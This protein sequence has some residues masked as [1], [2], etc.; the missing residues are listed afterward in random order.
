[1]IGFLD[2]AKYFVEDV[3]MAEIPQTRASL[4]VRL[5]DQQDAEAWRQFVQV[6]A[7]LVYQLCRRKGLQDADA[8][9]LTQEVLRHV[10]TSVGRLEYDPQ[11][12]LF[13]SW[14]FTLAHRK[15]VDYFR[16]R[17]RQEQGSG[18]SGIQA[19]LEEQPAL[20][21]VKQWDLDYQ[22]QVFAWAAEQVRDRFS[23]TTWQ[24]F[25]LTAVE[26]RDSHQTADQ[27]GMTV[28]AVYLAKSR[29]MARLKEQIKHLDAEE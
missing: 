5:R 2:P 19:I 11:R 10:S 21:E 25:W 29:V 27:L 28:A 26:N 22:R 14:L 1:V 12:G 20:D 6:Y 17:G 18:D 8:A 15:L 4:V 3:G 24:A 13:R 16:R 7:P 9:D 23:A